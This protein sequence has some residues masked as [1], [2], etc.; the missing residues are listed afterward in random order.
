MASPGNTRQAADSLCPENPTPRR[1]IKSSQLFLALSRH[2]Q[3]STEGN[4]IIMPGRR[5]AHSCTSH[6]IPGIAVPEL[7]PVRVQL[8]QKQLRLTADQAHLLFFIANSSCLLAW[9]GKPDYL[10]LTALDLTFCISQYSCESVD[11][12]GTSWELHVTVLL[13]QSNKSTLKGTCNIACISSCPICICI[14]TS[15][16]PLYGI[17][18]INIY[19]LHKHMTM[20]F[21]TM[22][23]GCFLDFQISLLRA[24]FELIL[25]LLCHGP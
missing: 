14:S 15:S 24:V 9:M 18:H 12:G 5:I 6:P 7:A 16:L 10:T 3:L 17:L 1:I 13:E 20:L 2:W 4:C 23:F 25:K 11:Y 8:V 21:P 19:Q 22:G